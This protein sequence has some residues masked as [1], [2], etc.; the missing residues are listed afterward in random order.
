MK[1]ETD[2][3]KQARQARE[4]EE[5]LRFAKSLVN[6]PKDLTQLERMNLIQEQK[7]E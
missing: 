2:E 7:K 4:A 3:E 5:A 1:K 6:T